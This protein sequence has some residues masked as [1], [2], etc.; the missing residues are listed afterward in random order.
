MEVLI[1]NKE[2]YIDS[3]NLVLDA[4]TEEHI[5]SYI[6]SVKENLISEHGF[7]RLTSNLGILIAHGKKIQ[8][9]ELFVEMMDLCCEQIPYARDK[10]GCN[11]GNEF[12]VKEI[13]FCLLEIEKSKIFDMSITDGWRKQLAEIDVYKTYTVI[14]PVPPVPTMNWASFSVASE[15]LR[16][17]A[18]IGCDE[19]FM[20]NQIKSQ[21]FAFDENGMY[22]DPG[23]PMVYELGSRLQ[24][25]IALHFGYNGESYETLIE[26]LTKSADITLKMQSVTGEIPY[27]GRS[28][29]F[30]HNEAMYAALCEFYAS[31]FKKQGDMEKAGKF[32][33][34][35]R[36]AFDDV[37]KWLKRCSKTH[38]KNAYPISSMYGCEKYAYFDKY[39]ITAAS[40]LYAAYTM[41]DDSIEEKNAPSETENYICILPSHFHKVFIKY[42]D[43]FAEYDTNADNGYDGNGLGRLHM[44]GIP[45]ALCLSTPFTAT[46]NYCLDIKN[47]T[48]FSICGGVK[49]DSGFMYGY[50]EN[51]GYNLI[52][53]NVTDSFSSVSFECK[54]GD[55]SF[56]QSL[57]LL[58][59]CAVVTVEGYGEVKLLFPVFDTDGE[60]KT[61]VISDENSVVVNYKGYR[62]TYIA[63]C[64][65]IN[66]L[67]TDYANRN[68][69]YS[70]YALSGNDKVK[71]KITMENYK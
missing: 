48:C 59:D 70:A 16:K 26:E 4:Y 52:H 41:A 64:G 50:E 60:E 54:K 33:R 38:I 53:K 36:L 14:V 5:R 63:E 43:W 61:T 21:I 34:A 24:L 17:Y 47:P 69:H 67:K 40:W 22:K 42:G 15:Q 39:M 6:D 13:I 37:D 32:K 19:I 7:P 49:K 51:V 35:A 29:Q 23:N 20:E 10:N 44:R 30:L 62:C 55:A 11:T 28:N 68:G 9:K 56:I 18:G 57:K 71:L 1:V 58:D 12:S 65:K 45:S 8:Y 3:M 25:A 46:P 66:N 2:I 31:F 27:G